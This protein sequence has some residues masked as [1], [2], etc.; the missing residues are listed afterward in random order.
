ML[1]KLKESFFARH[2]IKV[3]KKKPEDAESQPYKGITEQGVELSRQ[4]A[5]E[6]LKMLDQAE[7]GSVLFIGG[8]SEQIRTKSTGRVFGDEI[9]D[10]LAREGR[11]DILAL[12]EADIADRQQGYTEIVQG[13]SDKIN[14]S[15]DKKVLIDYPMLMKEFS[16]KMWLDEKGNFSEYTNK[17]LAK[18]NNNSTAAIKDWIESE[19]K[20]DDLTGPNPTK[21]AE[22][23]LKGIE[24]LRE[25]AKK[26]IKDRPVIVGAVG[27]SWNFDAL[28]VYLANNGKVDG[29]GFTKVGGE[30]IKDS[31]I[32]RVEIDKEGKAVLK[33]KGKEFSIE[34][35][36][37]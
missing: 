21:V 12:T 15:P 10:I 7:A 11:N 2:S 25:F 6:V 30:L 13:V 23:S 26:Y 4:K 28:A 16:M 37:N 17:L 27:H 32:G 34:L 20:L 19:G 5:Q 31:E 1:D 3:D 24:R 35:P 29:E 8:A 36:E 18:N 14:A 9:K 22:D 33:Y